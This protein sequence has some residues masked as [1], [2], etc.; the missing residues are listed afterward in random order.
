MGKRTQR[1]CWVFEKEIKRIRK[2]T[3]K[4][5]IAKKKPNWREINRSY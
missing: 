1:K 4:G 2:W 5:I 3:P